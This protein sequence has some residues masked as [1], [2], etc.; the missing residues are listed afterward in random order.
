M[1]LLPSVE[2]GQGF[3]AE[4]PVFMTMI[5][6]MKRSMNQEKASMLKWIV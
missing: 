4:N 1:V 6:K 2:M 3:G 5:I